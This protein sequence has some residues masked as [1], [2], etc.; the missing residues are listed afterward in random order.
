MTS[1]QQVGAAGVT[2]HSDGVVDRRPG[3]RGLRRDGRM[4]SLVHQGGSVKR[5]AEARVVRRQAPR[6]LQ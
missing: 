2:S 4:S 6:Y 1:D 5:E 3:T